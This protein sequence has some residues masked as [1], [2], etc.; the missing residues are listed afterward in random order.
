MVAD[1]LH[2]VATTSSSSSSSRRITAFY[3]LVLVLM[4]M[5][6]IFTLPLKIVVGV[7]TMYILS[8]FYGSEKRGFSHLH[9]LFSIAL[10]IKYKFF[11]MFKINDKI[12][13]IFLIYLK[14]KKY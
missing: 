12:S 10:C 4:C 9:C 6:T 13:S 11:L 2:V 14:K 7:A 5:P 1:T 8:T 3:I